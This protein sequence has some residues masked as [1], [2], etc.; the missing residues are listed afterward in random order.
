MVG[1]LGMQ[2][3]LERWSR[4]QESHVARTTGTVERASSTKMCM[5]K[6]TSGITKVCMLDQGSSNTMVWIQER[7]ATLNR[8]GDH[9]VEG[10]LR[11]QEVNPSGV[12]T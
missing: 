5:L 6:E 2:L 3:Y 12:T 8:G 4:L 9:E 10:S 1:M 7:I 11:R